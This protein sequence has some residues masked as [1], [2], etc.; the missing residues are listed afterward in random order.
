MTFVAPVSKERAT[1]DNLIKRSVMETRLLSVED[2]ESWQQPRFQRPLRINQKVLDFSEDLKRNG[3]VISGVI[4]LGQLPGDPALYKV[5]GAHRTEA[6]KMSGIKEFIADVRITQFESLSD[7]AEEFVRL[8]SS[9]VRMRPDDILRGLEE[10]LPLLKQLRQQC[11]FIGYDNV[12][13]ASSSS[14]VLSMSATLRSWGGSNTETPT[15]SGGA[16]G[17]LICEGL[18]ETEIAHLSAF[19]NTAYAAWGN[20]PENY[21]L[22]GNLNLTMC[23]WM[24]R[25]LVLKPA[26]AK[27]R[28]VSIKMPQFNKCL[29]SV[30]AASEYVDWLHGR[31]MGER[32]RS[33]CYRRLRAIFIKRLHED[34]GGP[35]APKLPA[36]AWYANQ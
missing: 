30:S 22:W 33:P 32:D 2:L 7:M 21:R 5:D 23:M 3:G 4:T 13:R 26:A 8:N 24:F 14:C 12:R 28:H 34:I 18:D 19:L 31:N 29:M 20:D 15:L 36:P 11:T 9:L 27:N 25:Q 1:G 35:R 10:N 17:H 16:P 6:A